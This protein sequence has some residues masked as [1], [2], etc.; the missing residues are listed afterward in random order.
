MLVYGTVYR[1]Q[2]FILSGNCFVKCSFEKTVSTA[3]AFQKLWLDDVLRKY[4]DQSQR[5]FA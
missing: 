1:L 3:S 2:P 5:V 4:P